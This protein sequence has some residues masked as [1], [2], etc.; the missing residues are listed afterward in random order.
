MERRTFDFQKLDGAQPDRVGA[1]R[2]AASEHPY[3]RDFWIALRLVQAVGFR[4]LTQPVDDL[5]M[6]IILESGE[7]FGEFGQQFD[8]ALRFLKSAGLLL[9][10]PAP[11]MT[12]GV[13]RDGFR[14]WRSHGYRLPRNSVTLILLM[15]AAGILSARGSSPGLPVKSI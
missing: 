1:L 4:Y 13:D 9:Q 12:D 3:V 7:V 8:V 15:C 2:S 11:H 10:N 14:A 5:E 6:R